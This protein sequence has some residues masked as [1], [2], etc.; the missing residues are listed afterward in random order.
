MPAIKWLNTNSATKLGGTEIVVTGSGLQG[1]SE[2]YFRD[3]NGNRYDVV[4]YT[5]DSDSQITLVSP[6]TGKSGRFDLYVVVGGRAA[7]TPLEN[8]TVWDGDR[9]GATGTAG[10]TIVKA[11]NHANRI[12]VD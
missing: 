1:A 7:T 11:Q 3:M 6:A 4:D 8:T 9:L 10:G 12:M 2:L 5:V